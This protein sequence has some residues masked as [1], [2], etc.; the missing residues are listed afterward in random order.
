M[1]TK[2]ETPASIVVLDGYTLNPGDL[3]WDA[4]AQLG[5]L[6]VYDRTPPEAVVERARSAS[7]LL[8]NK[9]RVDADLLSHLPALR[10][11]VVLA[12]GYNNIDVAAARARG[13]D[14]CNAVG[15]GSRE[16]AQ[17]AFALL[18][19]LTNQVALHHEAVQRGEWS[20]QPDFSLLRHPIRSL[21]GLQFGLFGLG[22]I[23]LEMAGIARAFGMEVS[24]VRAHRERPAPE[25][26]RLVDIPT[27][28]SESD[29]LCLTAP[30][31]PE[32]RQ[33]VRAET[34]ARMKPDALLVNTGRGELIDEPALRAA[35]LEGR[36]AGA[37]LDVLDGEPPRTDHPLFGLPNCIITPHIAWAATA[38]RRRL[39]DISVENVAAFLRGAP[40]H[41]VN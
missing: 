10:C 5:E 19:A 31:T 28:F 12:T 25:G 2:P 26:V 29:V 16:V 18:L 36:L 8:L 37:A 14:V 30:L 6:T 17:H 15:Y 35:L 1:K 39:M 7:V 40:I 22:R 41:V 11:I 9:V 21:A 23:G 38:A 32:T 4:L 34:L 27:L 20:A 33:V 24:A 3:S 13:I